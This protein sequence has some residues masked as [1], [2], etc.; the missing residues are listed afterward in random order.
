MWFKVEQGV[1]TM[2][3]KSRSPSP[4]LD[5]DLPAGLFVNTYTHSLDEKRRLIIPAVWRELVGGPRRVFVLPGIE[6]RC[7]WVYPA[8]E[9]TRRL[10]KL[11]KLSVADPDGRRLARALASRSDLVAWDSQGRMR[12]K[13]DLL[14]YAGLQNVVVMVGAFDRFE[15]WSP[16]EWK[17]ETEQV[18]EQALEEAIR[19]IGF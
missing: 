4:G 14:D 18:S 15:L 16:D 11:R 17:R 10:D 13:D 2:E 9:L 19:S 5:S 12:I 3:D 8:R 7:L 1:G 6:V